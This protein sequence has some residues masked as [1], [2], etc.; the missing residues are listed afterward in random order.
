MK[1]PG[2]ILHDANWL[3]TQGPR[4][5]RAV[6]LNCP[7]LT[8]WP[9]TMYTSM[10][11]GVSDY[12]MLCVTNVDGNEL[13]GMVRTRSNG[14]EA[15][16]HFHPFE[17]DKENTEL[18]KF[19]LT[20]PVWTAS[21]EPV[22][23]NFKTYA[24]ANA[25]KLLSTD[26]KRRRVFLPGE[27]WI[28][29]GTNDPRYQVVVNNEQV[30]KNGLTGKHMISVLHLSCYKTWELLEVL[31]VGASGSW[32]SYVLV[33][34]VETNGKDGSANEKGQ[35]TH[36]LT[37]LEGGMEV[38][39]TINA[40]DGAADFEGGEYLEAYLRFFFF[41]KAGRH[42]RFHFFTGR[43][44]IPV[45]ALTYQ[46]RQQL[47]AIE[48]SP[49]FIYGRNA[50][51]APYSMDWHCIFKDSLFSSKCN[52]TLPDRV[53]N[54][55]EQLMPMEGLHTS[56]TETVVS[57]A[58]VKDGG[59]AP[60]RFL[61]TEGKPKPIKS[62]T[63]LGARPLAHF[64]GTNRRPETQSGINAQELVA[65]LANAR[66]VQ[67]K[68]VSG[69]VSIYRDSLNS[70]GV[71]G[72]AVRIEACHFESEV[73]LAGL[74]EV[75]S[76]VFDGCTFKGGF[77]CQAAKLSCDVSFFNCVFAADE[78]TYADLGQNA[79][80]EGIA[81]V[82]DASN[83]VFE[84]S[85]LF[86]CCN[87]KGRGLFAGTE[88]AGDLAM[89]GSYVGPDLPDAQSHGANSR[90][91]TP[92]LLHRTSQAVGGFYFN[93]DKKGNFIS[94]RGKTGPELYQV[95]VGQP[96]LA[97]DHCVVKGNLELGAAAATYAPAAS[98]PDLFTRVNIADAQITVVA[99]EVSLK[100]AVVEGNS[101]M[102][103]FLGLWHVTYS[104]CEVHG[105]I[106]MDWYSRLQNGTLQIHGSVVK[107]SL[108]CDRLLCTH[109]LAEEDRTHAGYSLHVYQTNVGG[110][111]HMLSLIHI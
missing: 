19:L 95:F 100:N 75:G 27:D 32:A 107:G 79:V 46:Q 96:I 80:K 97:M 39:G 22:W 82:F 43:H 98:L 106:N 109:V 85:L 17:A 45:L 90:Y 66:T 68:K 71:D 110:N 93:E 51:T 64:R 84:G 78:P 57:G 2:L 25:D 11:S 3:P 99:G 87:L 33:R 86:W 24:E 63:S 42:G 53:I 13:Y 49:G 92:R 102:I 5:A 47:E 36:Q 83:A 18:F 40:A 91:W 31:Q 28:T 56:L 7:G 60:V 29:L 81:V 34:A 94:L 35:P 50:S 15:D 89:L 9:E 88:V 67:N 38:Y 108:L 65:L 23:V 10:I 4:Y 104:N 16:N 111:V 58:S 105:D 20:E 26:L 62:P 14:T 30:K 77:S 73:N 70:I 21:V 6:L 61:D 55:T 41:V 12:A 103:G 74:P 101:T 54:L 8:F 44:D 52:V 48:K 59:N 72:H 69:Q 37:P 76:V 1:S